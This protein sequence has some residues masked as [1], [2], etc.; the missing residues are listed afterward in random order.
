MSNKKI[1]FIHHLSV[2]GGATKSLLSLVKATKARGYDVTVLFY[3]EKGNAFDWFTDQGIVCHNF[4]N[5][6]VFQ[7]ANG[8]YIPLIQKRPYR[9]LTIFFKAIYSIKETKSI[10]SSFSP[11]LV[12]L[13]TSLLF[14]AA[15][16]AKQL[17]IKVIWHLREQIHN[18]LFGIRQKIIRFFFINYSDIII[19][20]SKT[21]ASKINSKKSK[22]I[23]NSCESEPEISENKLIELKSKL[24]ITDE[25][26]ICFLGGNVKSKGADLLFKTI[27]IL[28]KSNKKFIVII[29]GKFSLTGPNLNKIEI[30]V[31]KIID[32]NPEII[33]H[34]RFIGVIEDV[35]TL[36]KLSNFLVWP[37]NTSHFARPIIEAMMSKTLVLASDFESSR[38]IIDHGV[39]GFLAK[40]NVFDFSDQLIRL[41]D[42]N[43]NFEQI[44]L[45]AREKA[46]LLFSQEQNLNKNIQLISN[47]IE[48]KHLY[49]R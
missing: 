44:I 28:K 41:L 15:I 29:A 9:I 7:H 11:D 33:N 12:Y 39:T 32:R 21:N 47:T 22:V 37:A 10:I 13:N 45:N 2:I 4:Y 17:N 27:K 49:E 46:L 3:G 48:K 24:K 18:G 1:L 40:N 42:V 6:K 30:R 25:K 31:K 8:A 20:I 5:G 19:A 35:S 26:V 43:H 23:Y 36:L 38:E 16:A 34:I 14:P